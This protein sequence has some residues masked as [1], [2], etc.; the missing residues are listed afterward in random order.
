MKKNDFLDQFY[1]K[2]NSLIIRVFLSV[3]LVLLLAIFS[4]SF[5]K[6]N[7]FIAKVGVQGI[8][9]DKKE[10]IDQISNLNKNNKVKGLIVIINSPGGTYVGS[11]ELYDSI[12]ILSKKIPTV[13]YMR[14][15]ATSGGYLVSLSADKIYGSEGTITGSVGVIL[16][17]ADIS[18][19]LEKLGI[20]PIIVKS[21][22]FKSVPNPA[23]EIEKDEL[24]YLEN[25][26]KDMQEDFLDLVKKNRNISSSVLDLISDGRIFTGNQAKDLNLIDEVG[27]EQD[28]LKWLK[29][30]A[31]VDE[32]I[33][34][35][36]L[37]SEKDLKELFNLTFFKK[38]IN[39]LNQ[40][41]YN[42]IFAI[43]MPGI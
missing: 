16:Q 24:D 42:G 21:G 11:K 36:D 23:E 14:E 1:K 6:G 37:S 34:I 28:A 31:G 41:F 2:R 29:E 18:D 26:I 25:I 35:R 4:L 3:T 27:S 38:K 20:N 7:D 10:V 9:Q 13:V 19:L 5:Q 17:T 43:W 40:N 32:G 39:Y 30:K 8:I 12:K 22:K 33:K 15:M